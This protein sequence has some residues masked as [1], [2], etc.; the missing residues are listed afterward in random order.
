MN[1]PVGI[2]PLPG[3]KLEVTFQDGLQGLY[4]MS[5]SIGKGVFSLLKDSSKF[6]QVHIAQYGQITWSEEMEICSDAI[7]KELTREALGHA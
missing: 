3:W 4:D 1:R 7:H 6:N 2:K 5:A